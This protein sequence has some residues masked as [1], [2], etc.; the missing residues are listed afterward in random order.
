M[1]FKILAGIVAPLLSAASLCGQVPVGL[2]PFSTFL[3]ANTSV[4]QIA[5]DAQGFIYVYGEM[6][7]NGTDPENAGYNQEV[8]VA[9]LDPAATT[10]TYV[11]YLGGSSPT[12]PG[13]DGG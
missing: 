2:A 8:F 4:Q 12:Y 6:P 13:G 9:R 1:N 5:T 3:K 11:V 10:F 7:I